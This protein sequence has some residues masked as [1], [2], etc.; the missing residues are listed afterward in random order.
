VTPVVAQGEWLLRL[1]IEA[2]AQALQ[3]AN[4][5]QA[6][7]IDSALRRL[8]ATDEMGSLFKVI[9]LHSPDWPAPGGYD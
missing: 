5:A 9:A 3:R 6:G 2:R 7:E 8:T 4:P 1:G